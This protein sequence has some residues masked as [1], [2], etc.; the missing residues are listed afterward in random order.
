M[1]CVPALTRVCTTKRKKER[2]REKKG[3]RASEEREREREKGKA[4]DREKKGERD[5][6][7]MR[8]RQS[9]EIH[10]SRLPPVPPPSFKL[11]QQ[12]RAD[13]HLRLYPFFP[14]SLFVGDTIADYIYI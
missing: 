4:S 2:E 12:V 11:Q 5:A 13:L 3:D 8:A 9:N 7:C 10:R 14:I 6:E 1:A